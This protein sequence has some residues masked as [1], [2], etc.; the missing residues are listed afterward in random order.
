MSDLGRA[1]FSQYDG[2]H[3]ESARAIFYLMG[4][5]KIPGR[6]DYPGPLGAGDRRFRR[7]EIFVGPG[8][9]LDKGQ[10]AVAIDHD[11]VDFARFAAE[12]SREDF[13]ALAFEESLGVLLAPSAELCFVRQKD[14]LVQSGNSTQIPSDLT[15]RRQIWQIEFRLW[16]LL[17]R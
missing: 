6:T 10:R 5:Q 8:L 14:M 1:L 9:D 13:E 7:A 16:L 11:Q 15:N 2:D 3:V 4:G 17:L 12:I